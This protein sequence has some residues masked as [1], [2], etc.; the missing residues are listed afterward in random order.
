[1]AYEQPIFKFNQSDIAMD[2][3][4]IYLDSIHTIFPA[5][6]IK[7]MHF[8]QDGMVND[9]VIVNNEFIVRFSKDKQ[10]KESLASESRIL[11]LIKGRV[12]MSVPYFEYQ[13]PDVVIYRN[14]LGE[15]LTRKRLLR[16]DEVRQDC[17]VEQL[18]LFFFKVFAIPREMVEQL[19]IGLS[20]AKRSLEDWSA[21]FA[22]IQ[23]KFFPFILC[24]AAIGIW[25][26]YIGQQP[27]ESFVP[28]LFDLSIRGYAGTIA[29]YRNQRQE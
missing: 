5:L 20:E 6:V 1:M 12:E 27:D 21:M 13:A 15:P 11:K 28:G 14:Q 4:A 18:V 17:L 9:V 24:E 25:H 22:K 19:D 2:I 3:P 23:R 16:E 26:L 8:N 10:A 7:S 29:G